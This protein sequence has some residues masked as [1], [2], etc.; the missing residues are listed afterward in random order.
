M[1]TDYS[2][3]MSVYK[4]ES[5]E[6]LR[7]SIESMMKQTVPPSDFVLV[8]DGVLSGAH[9]DVI[10]ELSVMYP[11]MNILQ[12]EVPGGLGKALNYG[13]GYCKNDIVARMDSDDIALPDRMERQLKAFIDKGA[14]IVSGTVEEFV[15]TP[16]DTGIFRRLPETDEE[17][18]EFSKK[19]NP[20]NHPCTSFRK[21]RVY[22]AGGYVDTKWFED[23]YLWLRMLGNGCI[24]YNIP[25]TVLY[26]RTGNGMYKRRGGFRYI[27]AAV[28]FRKK[29]YVEGY[30]SLFQ[31][32][33]A[34]AAH[35]AS[36]IIPSGLRKLAY[37]KFLR[38]R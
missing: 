32:I 5:P 6:N 15:D 28:K 16:G 7:S 10:S 23:Y 21:Q 4:K 20:F 8:C 34:C 30:C 33:Y 36:S 9:Y 12:R 29:M 35:I 13:L 1:T 3:L 31:Y 14:D 17:I 26:M 24:G 11:V 38:N 18:V 27:S 22:M 2:V 37:S 25:E 19:R